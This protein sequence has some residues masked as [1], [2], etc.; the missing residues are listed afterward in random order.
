MDDDPFMTFNFRVQ[1]VIVGASG[2]GLKSP[3]CDS[4][5]AE[6][7]GLEMTMEPKTYRE[8][9]G[10]TEHIRLVGPVTYGTLT[11]KRGM[12]RNFDLWK[13]FAAVA[14]SAGK[15]GT[16]ASGVVVLRAADRGS[17]LVKFKLTGCLPIKIKAPSLN[18]R[19]GMV[20]I[21]EMQIAYRSFT[22]EGG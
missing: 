13:W 6:C 22:V 10:N 16:D 2:I 7:D 19:E 4:A 11:L 1:I 15:Q 8:G 17:D 21:E 5:F 20:A 3:L 12:T 9:G 18:A 14:G